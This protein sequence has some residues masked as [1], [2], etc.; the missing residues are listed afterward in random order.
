MLEPDFKFFAPGKPDCPNAS[1]DLGDGEARRGNE[2][3]HRFMAK[4]RAEQKIETAMEGLRIRAERPKANV[5]DHELIRRI[6]CGAYGEVWL[7]KSVLGTYRAVKVVHRDSFTDERPYER[8]FRG[9][10]K[11]EP[12]SRSNDG[13]MDILQIGRNETEGC[14]YYVMELADDSHARSTA[15]QIPNP[16]DYV[17]KTLQQVV[18]ER[19]RLPVE[20]CLQ[21][22]LPL[23]LALGHLHR[24]GLIHRDIK[25]SNIIFVSGIPKLADIG[26]VAELEQARSFVGTEGFIPP[27]GPNSP[28]ADLYSLGK[29]LYEMSM[30]KDRTQ[31]PEPFTLLGQEA[32]SEQLEELNAVILKACAPAAR[33]RYQ[34]AEEFHVDLALLQSGKSVKWK[35]TI[36][37]RLAAAR[38]WAAVVAVIAALSLAAYVFQRA[39]KKET[40]A[41]AER[42]QLGIAENLLQRGD[43][44][45]GLAN[46]AEVLRQ[47]PRQRVAAERILAA[48]TQRNFPRPAIR[49]LA[50]NAR[51][52]QR[53][54]QRAAHLSPDGESIVSAAEDQTV[55]V[56]NA[57]TGEERFPTLRFAGY[58]NSVSFQPDS[59]KVL[60]AF[61]SSSV[62]AFDVHSGKVIFPPLEHAGNVNAARFSPDGQWIATGD[63]GGTARIYR[64]E[65]GALAHGTLGHEAAVNSLEFSPDS[66]WLATASEDG[67]VRIWNVASGQLDSRFE[68]GGRVRFVRFSGNGKWLAATIQNTA[69]GRWQV[70]VWNFAAR[71]AHGGPLQHNN[72]IYSLDFSR[73]GER[74]VTSTA[75][76]SAWVWRV[77]TGEE[78][79]KIIHSEIVSSA[80]F[81]P[82]GRMILTASVD[83]TARLWDASTGAALCEPML[84]QGRV[85]QAEFSQDASQILT[86]S[87]E[88]GVVQLWNA[89]PRDP[90]HQTLPHPSWVLSGEFD[91]TGKK[92]I[93][94]TGGAV[95]TANGDNQWA[96]S[97][98]HYVNVW[99]STNVPIAS[100][101]LARGAEALA[102][103]FTKS[104]PRALVAVRD[105]KTMVFGR[106][107]RIWDLEKQALVG[108]VSH[109]AA[110]TCGRFSNDGLQVA[111]GSVDGT[112]TLWDARTC[113]PLKVLRAHQA[114]INSMRFSSNDALLVT[115]SNDQTAIIWDLTSGI[116]LTAPLKHGAEVWFAQFN[117]AGDKV[118]TASRDYTA[119]VWSRAGLL[120]AEL[121]HLAP[122][123]YAE[124]SADGARLITASGR[125]ARLWSI[126]TRQQLVEFEHQKG[127]LTARF[128]PDGLRVLTASFDGTAQ[129]WDAATGLKLA[130]PFRHGAAVVS[131][132]FNSSGTAAITASLDGTAQIW[133]IPTTN[134]ALTAH[135]PDLAEAIGGQRLNS[136]RIPE[137]VTWSTRQEILTRTPKI[138]LGDIADRLY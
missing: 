117:G 135:L 125:A 22:A 79:F 93:T 136:S 55:R 83:H 39:Q 2:G 30:G 132:N 71:K 42:W 94:A 77:A 24:H 114:R 6:G 72:R 84:H 75:D 40:E 43:S 78:L 28:Q 88:D 36:E 21:L 76:D 65:T 113:V 86:A 109:E 137:P 23:T 13:L 12:I 63:D 133:K 134:A 69:Q 68:N 99:A 110:A 108:T 7:A 8:E 105:P 119:R 50:H 54:T 60:I 11:F 25:P 59:S 98:R 1:A 104:G 64:A 138:D 51:L 67:S 58:V 47:N 128:S 95:F 124:F 66:Q 37:K 41:E 5:P 107:T 10:Q 27:E 129:L 61:D 91:A 101:A 89:P 57:R 38:K 100:R 3:E 92:A 62:Q 14:F 82:D 49:P 31:F 122:I 45:S 56:W 116:P 17:P 16:N 46:L 96:L 85:I 74:L 18:R 26:L 73:D 19:G 15:G 53:T 121:R 112:V 120:L 115:V 32:G 20:E 97:G 81:S 80:R 106:G 9:I 4:M 70:Q 35:Q 29:V 102:A 87:W 127:V 131:A 111:V 48:L 118:V 52:I 126:A 90:S 103:Q 33:D 130:D 34:T 123:D 44:A